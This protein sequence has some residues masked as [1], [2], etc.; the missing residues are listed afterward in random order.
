[1]AQQYDYSWQEADLNSFYAANKELIDA[2][3]PKMKDALKKVKK[4]FY[5]QLKDWFQTN[6]KMRISSQGNDQLLTF[7]AAFYLKLKSDGKSWESPQ[8]SG[9]HFPAMIAHLQEHPAEESEDE[10]ANADPANAQHAAAFSS[11]ELPTILAAMEKRIT[12]NLSK[13]MMDSANM[14]DG[15]S[16]SAMSH[17]L[18]EDSGLSSESGDEFGDPP[19]LPRA[20][21]TSKGKQH[22]KAKQK[23]KYED[24]EDVDVD[25]PDILYFPLL[26]LEKASAST[27]D[28][29][30]LVT[31]LKEQT[32]VTNP[33]HK[34]EQYQIDHLLKVAALLFKG[35]QE[36]AVEQLA[37]RIHF[38]LKTTKRQMNEAVGYYEHLVQAKRPQKEKEAYIVSKLPKSLPSKSADFL[39]KQ[40]AQGGNKG[41]QAATAQP[42]FGASQGGDATQGHGGGAQHQGGGG[43]RSG[44]GRH[45]G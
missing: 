40:V 3:V 7:M 34:A 5:Y 2:L 32:R 1:M 15:R 9:L 24:T 19:S 29:R 30:Q 37:Y 26:W 41:G 13:R 8:F 38:L 27:A 20:H 35:K 42:G 11:N 22:P 23:Q 31:T 39:V 17:I 44:R 21:Q 4:H 12:D 43:R 18:A 25:D 14:D 45:H 16:R 28:M 36:E 6:A 33:K 10:P